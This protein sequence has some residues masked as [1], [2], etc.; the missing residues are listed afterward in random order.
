[1]VCLRG[2]GVSLHL[3]VFENNFLS[4]FVTGAC[5]KVLIQVAPT[6]AILRGLSQSVLLN[7]RT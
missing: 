2:C 1:M 5:R 4:R 6:R 7:V 3:V